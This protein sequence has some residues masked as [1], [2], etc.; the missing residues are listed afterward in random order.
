MGKVI[1]FSTSKGGQGKTTSTVLCATALS[2]EPFNLNIA[3]I[4]VDTQKSIIKQ[5]QYDSE[6]YE[7]AAHSFD[8]YDYTT[9]K[10]S[11]SINELRKQYDL[12]FIDAAGK[13][14]TNL[15]LKE[16]EIYRLLIYTDYLFVPFCSGNY[17]LEST[18]DFLK[19]ALSV[20]AIKENTEAPLSINGYVGLFESRRTNDKF[21]K[22]DV[23]TITEQTGVK[24]MDVELKRLAMYSDSDTI[25]SL[26][27]QKAV[28][29][30]SINFFR[31][32]NELSTLIN[33]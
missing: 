26:Y 33:L 28:R 6:A 13:H 29:N 15:P 20:Q 18:L 22:K 8:V 31:W 16:Q 11:K 23:R 2:N 21:L 3:V 27:D 17:N 25:T 12:I 9:D 4:D 1:M 24:F 30:D 32:I 10:L 5:V 14:D 19:M 7:D